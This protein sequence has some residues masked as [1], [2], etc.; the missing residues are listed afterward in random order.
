MQRLQV[1]LQ[2]HAPRGYRKDTAALQSI[3]QMDSR[4]VRG[5]LFCL[6]AWM[7]IHSRTSYVGYRG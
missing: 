4:S 1:L 5:H 2:I 7:D 6:E 3:E